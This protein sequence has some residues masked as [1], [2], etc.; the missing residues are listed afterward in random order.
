MGA[1][2]RL[3][4]ARERAT[5][6]AKEAWGAATDDEEKRAE[7]QVQQKEADLKDAGDK[8]K[9]AARDVGEAFKR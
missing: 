1:D 8:A 6:R 9:D 2:D 4:N 7:G 3:D 5:G